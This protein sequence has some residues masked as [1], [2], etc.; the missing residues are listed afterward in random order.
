MVKAGAALAAILIAS[1][2]VLAQGLPPGVQPPVPAARPDSNAPPVAAMPQPGAPGVPFPAV[3][4][5]QQSNRSGPPIPLAS[6]PMSLDQ[7]KTD[8]TLAQMGSQVDK[9]L[10]GLSAGQG[11]M[12]SP[13]TT[14][15]RSELEQMQEEQ[16]Q[17]RILRLKQE[18]ADLA[19]KL[20]AT[21][22]DPR[23]EDAAA[24]A[25][26]GPAQQNA[27]AAI[28]TAAQAAVGSKEAADAAAAAAAAKPVEP[29]AQ[30]FP[31][32]VSISGQAATRGHNDG[33]LKAN[34]LVP[35]VGEV[36]AVVGTQLP[37]K[38]RVSA[39]T[40]DGVSVSDPKLGTVPLGYGDSVALAPP[41]IAP[42]AP[43]PGFPGMIPG[44]AGARPPMR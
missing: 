35:Y 15:Y 17:L 27:P 20:W 19:M 2:P 11:A 16:H 5:I 4:G 7:A 33:S 34:L 12:D 6:E 1:V 28:G 14:P 38:R 40:P 13:D 3:L 30:P 23:R 8:A 18:H 44:A 10:Q 9:R 22:F 31:K 26:G 43:A 29:D 21:T 37:G 42:A 39:I 32:V 24:K 25:A 36:T 41:P